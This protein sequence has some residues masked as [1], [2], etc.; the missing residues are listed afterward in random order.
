MLSGI[1]VGFV[2]GLLEGVFDGAT[3]GVCEGTTLGVSEGVEDRGVL[4]G[5]AAQIDVDGSS[6]LVCWV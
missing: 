4:L 6:K 3:L 5:A 2:V 1:L